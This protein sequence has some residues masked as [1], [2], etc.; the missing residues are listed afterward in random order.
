MGS[1]FRVQ[2]SGFRVLASGFRVQGVGFR[3]WG[4][5]LLVLALRAVLTHAP[6][7]ALR[8]ASRVGARDT[9]G[10]AERLVRRERPR[11][12]ERRAVPA[13]NLPRQSL[14]GVRQKTMSPS[15]EWFSNVETGSCAGFE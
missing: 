4:V 3:V 1:G 15:R 7:C 5:D 10:R 6:P 2:G 13:R 8:A 14:R 9:R 12:L 11:H